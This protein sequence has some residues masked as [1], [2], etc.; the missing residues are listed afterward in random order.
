LRDRLS[1]DLIAEV[2]KGG[3][4]AYAELVR[5][6]SNN[7]FAIC[8]GQLGDIHDAE[9]LTQ[10]VFIKAYREIQ[11]LKTD[12]QFKPWLNQIAR[13]QCVDLIRGRIRMRRVL[14]ERGSEKPVIPEKFD[15]LTD[16]IEKL[17]EDYRK[18]L[19]LYYFQKQDCNQVAQTLGL[20]PATVRT[21]LSRARQM[22]RELLGKRGDKE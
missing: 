14:N 22:L 7:V 6:H 2:K 21:R 1:K 13:N 19:A 8:L 4:A 16:A 11:S 12:E 18:P 15:A 10:E 20:A 17:D 5:R 3:K 9:D